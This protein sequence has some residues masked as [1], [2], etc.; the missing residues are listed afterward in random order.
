MAKS[1]F[2]GEL[3]GED[4]EVIHSQNKSMLGMK[5]RIVDE[6]KMTLVL[7]YRGARKVLLK[8]S[9]TIKL[10]RTGRVI[11]GTHILRRPEE[12]IK[13]PTTASWG[14]F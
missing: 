8:N 12:R 11:A 4:I 14:F 2:P 10:R 7:E 6:T 1:T 9:I 5:G 13:N 3:I